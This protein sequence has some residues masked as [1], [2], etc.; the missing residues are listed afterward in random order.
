MIRREVTV[1]R[2]ADAVWQRVG[3]YCAISDWLGVTCELDSGSGDVGSVRRLNGAILEPMVAR[4]A[5]SYTYWQSAG[6]MAVAAFH[7]TLAV[8]P[9]GPGRSRLSYTVFYDQAALPSD[10]VRESERARL[11]QRFVEPLM[12]MKR[13]AEAE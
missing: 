10:E 1:D 3:E 6:S 9:D 5:H 12:V 4:T 13:L 2:P 7:G 8:E 11:D